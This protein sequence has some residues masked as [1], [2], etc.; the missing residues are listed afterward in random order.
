MESNFVLSD[1]DECMDVAI[2]HWSISPHQD[3][4]TH[5]PVV[6]VSSNEDDNVNNESSK[7]K[8]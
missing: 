1:A 5:A 3:P 7:Q 8:K 2:V 6:N 4:P